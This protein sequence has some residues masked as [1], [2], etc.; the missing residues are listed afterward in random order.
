MTNTNQG[1]GQQG[2]PLRAAVWGIAA[3]A[4]L[5]P[6]MAMQFTSEVDWDLTDFAVFG[7]MLLFVCGTYELATRLTGNK[8]YR[9][10]VSIAL[11]GAFL[12]TWVNLAV[13]IIGN[14]GNLANLMFFAVPLVGMVGALIARFKPRGMARALVATAIIQLLVAVI[15]L[16]AGWGNAIIL[17][18][19][20]I[21]MWL[22][23][24]HLFRKA[25]QE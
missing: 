9:L 22:T 11:S 19:F 21:L 8:A 7:A 20:I 5:L 3:F 18:G 15:A 25:A 6:W 4:L 23:S 17:T 14:E 13:G 12:L 2:N 1:D 10:A 16:I 24:A